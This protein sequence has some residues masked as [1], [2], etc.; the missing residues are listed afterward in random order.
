MAASND[1]Y[2]YIT[3]N[4]GKVTILDNGFY[5]AQDSHGNELFINPNDT[6]V[7]L[8]TLYPGSGGSTNDA[9]AVRSLM[10]SD[11]PPSYSCVISRSSSDPYHVLDTATDILNQNGYTIESLATTGFSR[12]GGMVIE[13]TADYLRRHPELVGSTSII[14]MMDIITLP[15]VEVIYKY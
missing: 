12:S 5:Y 6:N 4:F 3:A 10:R 11:T 15:N 14:I 13:R 9:R 1:L 2:D 8:V 7:N